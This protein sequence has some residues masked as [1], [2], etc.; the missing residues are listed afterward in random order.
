[1]ILRE[2]WG[3][4]WTEDAQTLRVHVSNLRKKLGRSSDGM[5]YIVTEPGVGFR[6][7]VPSTQAD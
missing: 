4:E 5:Q 7:T 3:P 6:L 2:V 1:M